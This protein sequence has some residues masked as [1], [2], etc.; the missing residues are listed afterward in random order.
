[1]KKRTVL[2]AVIPLALSFMLVGCSTG[3][4]KLAVSDPEYSEYVGSW[5]HGEDP[6]GGNLSVTIKSIVDGKMEWTFTDSYDNSTL[7]QEMKDTVV[8]DDAAAFDVQGNDAE[9]KNTT[10]NY[11][12]TMELKDGTVVM[13]FENGE[14][15]EGGSSST[16][17][18][19][20]LGS[21]GLSDQVTLAKPEGS[22][23]N[24]Y[25]VQSGDSIHSIAKK[26]GISTRDLAIMNQTVIIET[27]QKNGYQFDDVI[28]YAKYLFPG[29]VL[30]VPNTD[31]VK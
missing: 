11:Q 23:L 1:M 27:A 13:K 25:T 16:R 22:E 4:E 28:E 7:Y 2:K 26:Y 29:E 21:S 24:T 19:N 9:N 6:W 3:T 5:F 8:K 17:N 14:V 10:F 12:G 31:T 20:E 15:M 18:V 30:V